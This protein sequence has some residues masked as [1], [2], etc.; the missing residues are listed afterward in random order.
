MSPAGW[1]GRGRERKIPI[2][3]GHCLEP[4]D[5]AGVG[6][7]NPLLAPRCP[8]RPGARMK[9]QL[10][11]PPS[12]AWEAMLTPKRAPRAAGEG[13]GTP[14]ASAP[15][16]S[17]LQGRSPAPHSH[18]PDDPARPL[19]F[20]AFYGHRLQRRQ[21]LPNPNGPCQTGAGTLPGAPGD[22]PKSCIGSILGAARGT[23]TGALPCAGMGGEEADPKY[24]ARVL[25]TPRGPECP[26]PKPLPGAGCAQAG[27]K[28]F[29]HP[30]DE[31]CCRKRRP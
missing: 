15:T 9:G 24:S 23:P 14:C 12:P 28:A 19:R 10:Y 26:P 17:A 31:R 22:T 18:V 2:K 27:V 1:R 20:R 5:G 6:G 7:G 25:R 29:P 3:G 4:G 8:R 21:M 13:Q 16:H 30:R 11:P